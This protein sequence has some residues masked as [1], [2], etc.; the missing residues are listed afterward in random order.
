MRDKGAIVA[1]LV[2]GGF[3]IKVHVGQLALPAAV[4]EHTSPAAVAG[5]AVVV[6]VVIFYFF[7]A[8]GGQLEITG[9]DKR[10]GVMV[11][12]GCVDTKVGLGGKGV[13]FE[14]TH[15]GSGG[16]RRGGHGSG[17][18]G[19]WRRGNGQVQRWEVFR[20]VSRHSFLDK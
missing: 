8:C 6:V 13:Y 19:G 4:S 3:V 7:L 16:R 5:V 2:L 14:I 9:R 12:L 10:H 18:C 11:A 20:D 15:P 17:R 1:D